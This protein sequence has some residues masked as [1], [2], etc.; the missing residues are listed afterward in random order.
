M[1]EGSSKE[2]VASKGLSF[3]IF[4]MS[5]SMTDGAKSAFGLKYIPFCL[6]LH[7]QKLLGER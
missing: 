7:D 1:Y 2:I 4:T 5:L 3:P 6:R